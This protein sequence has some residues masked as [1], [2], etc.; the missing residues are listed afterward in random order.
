MK[1]KQSSLRI[2]LSAIAALVLALAF[3]GCGGKSAGTTQPAAGGS[4]STTGFTRGVI[5]AFGTIHLG[6]GPNEKVFHAEHARLKRVDDGVSHDSMDDD[7]LVFRRGM[8]VEIFHSAGDSNAVEVRYMNDLEGPITAKPSATA[9]ATF[10]VLAVPVLVDAN[11]NFDDSFGGSGLT[12][13]G[14]VVGNVVEI[15]GTF[16]GNGVLHA[17]FIEGKHAS[18]SGR[19]FEIKGTISDLAGTAPDQTFKVKGASFVTDGTSNLHDLAGGLANGQFVEVKTQSTTSP[20]L[21]T[22]IES[23]T[24]D[25]ENPE[26]KVEGA[27]SASVEGIVA[28]LSGSSP[29]FSFTLDGTPVV[30]STATTG[31]ALVLPN[32]HL[33]A[34]GP[35]GAGGVINA[36]KITARP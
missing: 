32:A 27:A 28:G 34:E 29:S 36:T 10:D 31:L 9:G 14:L 3:A 13:A 33:E 35:V 1:P 18:S 30:T 8:E 23:G 5:R 17:T 12:L 25:L 19:T 20:F 16:D 24:G 7:S 11:T 21:V 22:R 6:T 4:L 15:S 26:K 2:A